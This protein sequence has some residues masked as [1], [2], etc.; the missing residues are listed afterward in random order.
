MGEASA[1]F[2]L[3]VFIRD[4]GPLTQAG[5]VTGVMDHSLD[6]LITEMG[7]VK[8]VYVDRCGVTRHAFR[9]VSGIDM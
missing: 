7:V 3:A 5:V 9:R 6:V 2:F 8:R 1:E 4:C